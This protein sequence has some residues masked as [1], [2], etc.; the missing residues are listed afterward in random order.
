MRTA[1]I[2]DT[3]HLIFVVLDLFFTRALAS[4]LPAGSPLVVNCV[5]PG[6]CYLSIRRNLPLIAKMGAAIFEW[7]IAR[8]TTTGA[9]I[10]V[11]ATLAGTV[12]Q[13]SSG[14]H[15]SLKGAYV[16]D[17]DISEPSDFVSYEKGRQSEQQI[18]VGHSFKKRTRIV[19]LKLS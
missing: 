5:R 11:W 10:L 4:H 9:S 17:W 14:L 16:A 7:L 12:V 3:H 2:D 6:F 15:D 13:A 19:V 1:P 18:W 8:S